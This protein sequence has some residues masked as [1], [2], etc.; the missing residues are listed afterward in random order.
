MEEATKI[1]M[2][3]RDIYLMA[4]EFMPVDQLDAMQGKLRP[5][6]DAFQKVNFLLHETQE[7]NVK[8]CTQ[9]AILLHANAQ[10]RLQQRAMACK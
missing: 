3:F 7:M 2:A 4:A 8:V 6:L 1:Q 9:R 10:M 5:V